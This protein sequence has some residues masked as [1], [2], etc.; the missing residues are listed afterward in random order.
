MCPHPSGCKPFLLPSTFS[1]PV[2]HCPTSST[3]CNRVTRLCW[4]LVSVSLS[5]VFIL[6]PSASPVWLP[7]RETGA[8]SGQQVGSVGKGY[9]VGEQ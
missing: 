3:W 1:P 7:W 2:F 8:Q 6:K 5:S 9:G 4:D